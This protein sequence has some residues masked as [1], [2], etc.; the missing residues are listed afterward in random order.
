LIFCFFCIK[1]KEVKKF[2]QLSK[3]GQIGFVKR[4]TKGVLFVKNTHFLGNY[5]LSSENVRNLHP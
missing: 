3:K 5:F 4:L 2:K 1:T